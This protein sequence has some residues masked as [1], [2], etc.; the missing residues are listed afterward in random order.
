MIVYKCLKTFFC[1]QLNRYIA[2]DS[3]VYR[4][5]NTTKLNISGSPYTDPSNQIT[6]NSWEF[7]EEKEVTWFYALEPVLPA[8]S[9]E[10]FTYIE[11]LPEDEAGGAMIV[12]FL[13]EI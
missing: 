5:E 8:T 12:L 7:E 1:S 6:S 9:S 3:I 4:Y 11:T 13:S 2:A 10:F